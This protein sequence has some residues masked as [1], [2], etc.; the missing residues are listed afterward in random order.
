MF[1]EV[2]AQ[3]DYLQQFLVLFGFPIFRTFLNKLHLKLN[4]DIG[5]IGTECIVC[6]LL[7]L[8]YTKV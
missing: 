8:S 3:R 4:I 7:F 2:T 6:I 1:L 5:G